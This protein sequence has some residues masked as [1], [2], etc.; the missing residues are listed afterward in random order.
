MPQSDQSWARPDCSNFATT[1]GLRIAFPLGSALVDGMDAIVVRR[2]RE[3]QR[4][5][6]L[7]QFVDYAVL[8]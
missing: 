3:A 8:G 6:V 2:L 5:L 1:F 4:R 7:Q